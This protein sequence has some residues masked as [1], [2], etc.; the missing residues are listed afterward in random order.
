MN[1]NDMNTNYDFDSVKKILESR[2]N[3]TGRWDSMTEDEVRS[4]GQKADA[5]L[6][7][8]GDI[9]SPKYNLYL[10]IREAAKMRLQQI[11]NMPVNEGV[12]S[13]MVDQA[14]VVL[15]AQEIGDKLQG[16][17]EDIAQM[18]VQDMMPL[19]QAMKE[20]MGMDQASAFESSATASLQGL[21]DT[22][23]STKES[24]DN[25]VLVLQGEAPATDMGMDDGG[26]D[27][28]PDAGIDGEPEID[29]PADD[30]SGADAVAG[31]DADAGR[32]MKESMDDKIKL[33]LKAVQESSKDGKISKAELE[34]I[35]SE[36]TA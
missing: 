18:Q 22:M 19:V 29:I 20:Q 8:A 23:K 1:I 27:A 25:A 7:E 24:Y 11:A 31:D 10:F 5:K 32:E 6:A 26:I 13:E 35:K 15:A 3:W 17:A 12:G 28:M 30:F 9:S 2:F 14:E 33:A 36:A 21:L 16:M 4:L 34:R